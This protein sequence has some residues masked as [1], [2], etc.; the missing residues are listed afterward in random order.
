MLIEGSYLMSKKNVLPIWTKEYLVPAG[1]R[2]RW[3]LPGPVHLRKDV[4][5]AGSGWNPAEGH[6]TDVEEDKGEVE[7]IIKATIV[8]VAR[9]QRRGGGGRGSM[10]VARESHV[11]FSENYGRT[12]SVWSCKVV[13]EWWGVRVLLFNCLL[14]KIR[15]KLTIIFVHFGI[16]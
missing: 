6:G 5:D 8:V 4:H 2:Y 16:L 15:A 10:P 1:Q 13:G 9:A 3:P 11:Q 12:L 14:P 7:E